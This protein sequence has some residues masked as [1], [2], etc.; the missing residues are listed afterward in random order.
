MEFIPHDTN[1]DFLGQRKIA[2]LISIILLAAT[3]YIWVKRGPDKFGIDFRGGNEIVVQLEQ[4]IETESLANSLE[5]GGLNG[6][7]VQSFE[8]GSHEYAIRV[9]LIEGMDAKAIR[10]KVEASLKSLFG[11]AFKVIK[12]DSVGATIGDELKR[13]AL[14]A[15]SLGVIGVLIYIAFRF[16]FSF[17]LGAVVAMFHDVIVAVGAFLWVGHDLNGSALAAAL[18]IVGY[19]VN[20]TIVIF[21]RVREEMRRRK[22][23][24][25]ATLMNQSMNSC[26]SRTI[27]TSALTLFAVAAL[28]VLGGGSI[29]D[30]SLFLLAG[31]VSG[32]YSTV[33]IAAPVAL[34]WIRVREYWGKRRAVSGGRA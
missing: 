17:G 29:Q 12:T 13:K 30:L 14:W 16:E 20:D 9:G 34:W 33:Y 10:E 26:L 28:L 21:D 32:V 18:T 1:I 15:I 31:M 3:A 4:D 22:D 8:K 25:L 24:D 2:Y 11:D 23:A 19:S 6:A 5:N 7:S 27:I